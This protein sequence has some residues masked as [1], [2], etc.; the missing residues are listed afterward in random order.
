MCV[1]RWGDYRSLQMSGQEVPEIVVRAEGNIRERGGLRLGTGG[2]EGVR[3]CRTSVETTEPMKLARMIVEDLF[4]AGNVRGLHV[5]GGA[6]WVW[7]GERWEMKDFE[8]LEN[9]V[10]RWAEDL[11]VVVTT[12][13]GQM[14]MRYA[15]KRSNVEEVVRALQALCTLEVERVPCWLGEG[16]GVDPTFCVGFQDVVVDLRGS[17]QDGTWR[18]LP[19][20]SGFF[21][22]QTVPC[23]WE[24]KAEAPFWGRMLGEWGADDP[25]FGEVHERMCGYALMGH[26][27]WPAWFLQFG[28]KRGGKG[29]SMVPLKVMQGSKVCVSKELGNLMDKHSL[30]GIQGWRTLLITE[31]S[32]LDKWEAERAAGLVKVLVGGD[33]VSVRPLY[34]EAVVVRPYVLPIMQSNEVPMLPDKGGGLSGKMVLV[35]F[36]RS[37]LKKEDDTIEERLRAEVPGIARRFLEAGLR[38]MAAKAPERWPVPLAAHEAMQRYTEEVNPVD[39]FLGEYFVRR[40]EGR[41]EHGILVRMLREYEERTGVNFGV[42]DKFVSTMV[43]RKATWHLRKVSEGKNGSVFVRGLSMKRSG[44]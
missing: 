27:R 14:L 17:V 1:V 23:R 35:P 40:E 9:V 42:G 37:W 25:A 16:G 8:W 38:L 36:V 20:T 10:W 33:D 13:K 31:V 41:V 29:M 4:Q 11:T 28:Q 7:V 26:R 22:V 30:V 24:P 44:G 6:V 18:V 15:P 39:A 34:R 21:D 3:V 32:E 5:W 43:V 2:L 12:A 19:R